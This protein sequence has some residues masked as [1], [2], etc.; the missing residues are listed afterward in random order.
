MQVGTDFQIQ[1]VTGTVE[2]EEKVTY[3]HPF[4]GLD[5]SAEYFDICLVTE[6]EPSFGALS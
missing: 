1:S 5:F 2:Q 6:V 4:S 3:L